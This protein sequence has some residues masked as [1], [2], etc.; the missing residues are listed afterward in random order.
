V[1]ANLHPD[2][3]TVAVFRRTNK[4]A[5]DP[6]MLKLARAIVAAQNKEIAEMKSWQA[7][8]PAGR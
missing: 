1:A 5:I 4:A 3:D 7:K 6:A 2:H 8:H